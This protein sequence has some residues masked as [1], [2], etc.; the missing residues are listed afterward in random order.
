M[1]NQTLCAAIMII[2]AS[3]SPRRALLL[4]QAGIPFRISAPEVEEIHQ[5]DDAEAT[6]SENCRR[7]ALAVSRKFP[8]ELVLAADTVVSL[9]G[10][11][12]GKPTDLN[13][14]LEMLLSL[15]GR[16]HEVL[17]GQALALDGELIELKVL[18]APVNF[19]AFGPEQAE[20]YFDRVNPL[21][22]A[23]AYNLGECPELLGASCQAD[24]G[25]VIGLSINDLKQSLKNLPKPLAERFPTL[26]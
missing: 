17:T 16:S 14:A 1:K 4:Q 13:A 9:D 20:G 12:L 5:N 11:V 24:H 8:H 23:G 21:D 25:I 2:L 10:L 22:K 26:L 19:A 3:T 7:K 18:R 6:V 15:S